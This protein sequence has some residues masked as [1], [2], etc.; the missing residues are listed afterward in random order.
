MK[1]YVVNRI[2]S[3]IF[4]LF[5][6]SIL[7]FSLTH[8]MSGDPA[9]IILG[10]EAGEQQLEALRESMGLNDSVIVQYLRWLGNIFHGDLGNSYFNN[11]TVGDLILSHM[12]ASV[13]LAIFAEI[14]ALLIAIPLGVIGAQHK[15]KW[16]DNIVSTFSM[17][18]MSLPDFILALLLV[19]LLAVQFKL[20]PVSGYK[21]IDTGIDVWASYLVLPTLA[22]AFRQ[23]ALIV[24]TTRSSMLEVLSLDYIKTVRAKGLK[25]GKIM[26][27]HA[28]RNALVTIITVIGQ[29][30]GS[31]IAGTAVV[32]SVFN[33]PGMGQLIVSSILK[34]DYPTIQGVVLV[35]GSM[36]I[37]INLATDLIYGFINPK[38]R[39]TGD[40]Q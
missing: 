13:T 34:R 6:L 31:L 40:A 5:V 4:T 26:Y 29:T 15:G 35:I 3:V 9:A 20:F 30:F 39:I 23:A 24:R 32:E 12:S 11:N 18:G 36:Y 22:L 8:I 10:S 16:Q 33:I 7:T 1:K 2:L 14:V 27:K 25:N 28:L 37:L 17:A 38:I 21:T 19:L